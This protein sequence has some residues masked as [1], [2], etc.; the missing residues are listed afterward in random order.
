LDGSS[1]H[2]VSEAIYLSDPEGNGIEIYSDRPH[3]QWKFHQDGMVEMA[4]LRPG[5]G[6]E[7]ADGDLLCLFADAIG[8]AHAV[9]SP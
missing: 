4:T 1:D 5:A 3:E 7:F 8:D 9:R 6:V 2:L